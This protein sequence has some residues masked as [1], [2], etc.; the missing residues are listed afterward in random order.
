[1]YFP[2]NLLLTNFQSAKHPSLSFCNRQRKPLTLSGAAM[3]SHQSLQEIWKFRLGFALLNCWMLFQTPWWTYHRI[4]LILLDFIFWLTPEACATFFLII[5]RDIL[6]TSGA[7]IQAAVQILV[8]KVHGVYILPAHPYLWNIVD[9]WFLRY[10]F[11][12]LG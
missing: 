11:W 12:W 5:C 9:N 8:H 6:K 2:L 1:M 7:T 4:W 3:V 10:T